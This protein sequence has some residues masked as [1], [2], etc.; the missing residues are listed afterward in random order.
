MKKIILILFI[1]FTVKQLF[2]FE[3]IYKGKPYF[4]AD[5]YG[6][7]ITRVKFYFSKEDHFSKLRHKLVDSKAI[8]EQLDFI[9]SDLPNYGPRYYLVEIK[10]FDFKFGLDLDALNFDELGDYPEILESYQYEI[11][12]TEI[13][14]SIP[15]VNLRNKQ[16][17]KLTNEDINKFNLYNVQVLKPLIISMNQSES[18]KKFYQLNYVEFPKVLKDSM[19]QLLLIHR[20][21]KNNIQFRKIPKVVINEVLLSIVVK[22]YFEEIQ[23]EN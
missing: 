8:K 4:N 11:K 1:L 19:F 6:R 3:K 20:F 12:V 17:I 21:G 15:N 7:N 16:V 14:N 10:F 9:K 5:E 22:S 23:R 2:A 18:L 13:K